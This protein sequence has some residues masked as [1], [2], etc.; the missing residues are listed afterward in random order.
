M[1]MAKKPVRERQ[2]ARLRRKLHRLTGC[3]RHTQC[4]SDEALKI[5]G[6]FMTAEEADYSDVC[7]A[8][9]RL[10]CACEEVLE[11]LCEELNRITRLC[12]IPGGKD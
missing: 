1:I 11:V 7:G 4:V 12:E 8:V 3:V 9:E 5:A 6:C 2:E 10:S